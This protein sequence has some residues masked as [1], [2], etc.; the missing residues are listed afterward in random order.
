[1]ARTERPGLETH[2][3]IETVIVGAGLAGLTAALEL[4]RA[5]RSV[6]LLEAKRV[7]WGASGRNG[8]FV[9]AGFAAG[10]PAIEKRLGQA[11]AK[12]LYQLSRDGVAYVRNMVSDL[13]NGAEICGEGWLKVVRYDNEAAM[14]KRAEEMQRLYDAPYEFWDREA[15]REQLRSETYHQALYDPSAFH[16]QP[17]NYALALADEAERLGVRLYENSPVNRLERAGAG[18]GWK[19]TTP[20]GHLTAR[21]VVLCGSAYM[22]RLY[23]RLNRAVL[24]VAT[25]I[26]TSGPMPEKLDEAIRFSGCIADTRRAGDYYRRVAGG[27]L[28]WGGRITTQ[29]SEPANLA[30]TLKADILKIYPQLGDFP[31]ETAWSGLMGYAVHKMPFIGEYEPGL[32]VATA[33]GGHGLAQTALGGQLVASGIAEGDDRWRLFSSWSMQWG[34]GPIGQLGTQLAYWGMQAQAWWDE[35]R[36]GGSLGRV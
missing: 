6:A 3:E 36:K 22:G 32:W 2:Y 30:E 10:M 25:Y 1:M 17:L 8:G 19:V 21:H 27:R 13:G 4:A 33:F 31:V 11:D 15:V 16:I 35:K 34:G 5:G 29:T 12:E 26:L 7:G 20:N 23:P 14:R 18:Q 24:P 9:S 28:L